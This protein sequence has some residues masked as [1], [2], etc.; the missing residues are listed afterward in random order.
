MPTDTSSTVLDEP[1]TDTAVDNTQAANAPTDNTPVGSVAN[2][3]ADTPTATQPADTPAD[4]PSSQPATDNKPVAQADP[5]TDGG[6]NTDGSQAQANTQDP[7]SAGRQNMLDLISKWM[8]TSLSQPHIPDGET[9]DLMAKAGWTKATGD[10]NKKLK[11]NGGHPATSCGDILKAM[12][13]LW[14]S[15]FIAAF[16]IRDSDATGHGPGAK[17]L[18]Y[19]VVADG[20]NTPKP[21]DIVVLRNGF[22]PSS[23]GSV[24]H[25]GILVSVADDGWSTADGGGGMLPDQTASVSKRTVRF[26]NKIA[27]LKSPTDGK[28]K[29]LD[30]WV[31]LDKLTQGQ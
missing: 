29:Q 2:A 21:G 4:T 30:G 11:D 17:S 22:G 9:V 3:P 12:L 1:A 14:K 18:G 5:P 28:E 19:Y 20:S 13:T 15:N 23:V 7:L 25:V 24:G 8:P 27:I 31:D 16:N 6:G 26:D 10:D